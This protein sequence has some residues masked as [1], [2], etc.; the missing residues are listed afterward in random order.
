MTNA[1]IIT[2]LRTVAGVLATD[3]VCA[4]SAFVLRKKDILFRKFY[5][6]LLTI[7]MFFG[8]G[9]IPSYLNL[10]MFGLLDNFLVYII[11]GLV[12]FFMIIIMMTSFN[13]IPD[14]L[15]ESAKIDG[16]GYFTI[17][18]RIYVPLSL[19]VLATVSLFI[20]VGQ[21][22]SWFDTM[23]FTSSQSLITLQAI[24][25]RTI[26]QSSVTAEMQMMS[27]L[28]DS[29][30]NLI[31]PEGIKMATMIVT[32]LPILFIYPFLQRYFVKGVM[33][34]SIKG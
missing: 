31:S 25:V 28:K 1:F 10:K 17:F 5:L 9:L 2:V 6:I 22:N 19:P 24:L 8:G 7:P 18:S 16:A 21:W 26:T 4:T 33:I 12:S 29:E 32:V 14:A 13:D 3:F 20:G 15:E 34:G 30:K 11:P 23:Y 27:G